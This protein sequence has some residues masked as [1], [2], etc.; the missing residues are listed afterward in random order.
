MYHDIVAALVHY[1]PKPEVVITR[2]TYNIPEKFQ[3]LITFDMSDVV[4]LGSMGLDILETLGKAVAISLLRQI[5][6]AKVIHA[7]MLLLPLP[8]R[9]PPSF[10]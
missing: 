6:T 1:S 2:D 5:I 7:P 4:Y 9:R 8:V 3:V 10:R